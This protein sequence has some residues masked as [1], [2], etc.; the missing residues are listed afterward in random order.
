[1]E[2]LRARI[3]VGAES[4]SSSGVANLHIES[5][6]GRSNAVDASRRTEKKKFKPGRVGPVAGVGARVEKWTGPGGRC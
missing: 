2:R 1:M 3:G 4:A 6:S 5:L